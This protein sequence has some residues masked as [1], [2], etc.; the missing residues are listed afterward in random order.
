MLESYS[1]LCLLLLFCYQWLKSKKSNKTEK[2]KLKLLKCRI[3]I[4]NSIRTLHIS[5]FR[6]RFPVF[7]EVILAKSI[8]SKCLYKCMSF[9]N[10]EFQICSTDLM[11]PCWF[12]SY[13]LINIIK[14][15]ICRIF[16]T[17]DY[18]CIT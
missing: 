7:S 11:N 8:I 13:K 17:F 5:F 18:S 15:D 2:I 9:K 4:N 1:S 12:H 14:F 6:T 16:G 10:H 3:T